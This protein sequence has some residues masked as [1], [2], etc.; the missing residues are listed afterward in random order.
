MINVKSNDI[1][2]NYDVFYD[3]MLAATVM[4]NTYSKEAIRDSE[5]ILDFIANAYGMSKAFTKKVKNIILEKLVNLSVIQDIEAYDAAKSYDTEY[6]ELDKYAE[7]KYDIISMLIAER[8]TNPET[9]YGWVNYEHYNVYQANARFRKL[10]QSATQGDLISIRQTAILRALGIGCKKNLDDAARKLLQCALWGD[11]QSTYLLSHVCALLGK[12]EKAK[13]FG[14][15]ATL[16]EEYL[17]DGITVL[18]EDIKAKFSEEAC[19]YYVYISSIKYD[20]I[21]AYNLR[22]IDFSFLEVMMSD[23][24]EHT[25]KMKYI[26]EYNKKEWKNC[27]NAITEKQRKCKI[28]F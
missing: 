12:E 4:T 11:V 20:V 8:K 9:N 22:K 5:R 19:M 2:E 14:E 7:V 27:T 23:K 10:S 21:Y 15:L 25:D 13:M 1:F 16:T 3:M 26:N 18:P 6:S 28:G 17:D 24:I